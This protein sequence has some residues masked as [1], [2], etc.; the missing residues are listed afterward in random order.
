[1]KI[2]FILFDEMTALDLVGVY[3]AL[4]RLNTMG[5][6]PDVGWDLCALSS[7]V[8]AT[9]GMRFVATRSRGSLEGYDLLV[10]PGGVGT[11]RLLLQN[12]E[13]YDFIQWIQ[14][15][16][17]VPLK[18]SVCTGALILGI[19]GFLQGKP[20]TT[21]PS[22]YD[23][24]AR[25]CSQVLPQ[26]IVDA[27]DVITAGGVAASLDLGLYLVEKFSGEHGRLAV[28][29]QMDYPAYPIPALPTSSSSSAHPRTS[30]YQ[31]RTQETEVRILLNLDGTGS[32]HIDT[33]IGFLD[34]M[35]THLAVH[36]LFDLDIQ[37]KGDL[38]V[39]LHHTVED[40]AL[41]LGE[42]FRQ[43]LGDRQG[44]VRMASAYAPMDESLAFVAVD[45]SGRPYTVFEGAWHSPEVG[46][47]PTSLFQHFLES[48][49]NN[50]RCNLHTR[51]VAGRDDHHQAEALFK[52][53]ARALDAATHLDARRSGVIPSTKGTLAG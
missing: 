30:E 14:T 15:G 25:Y 31:R 23:E 28:Q 12:Q 33:G 42:S 34:H 29:K 43:A 39:D 44:I 17:G 37:A 19:A 48:F 38:F 1:M 16:Q 20:A 13:G 9:G 11:R 7:E 35:L 8:V 10:V 47:I 46:G 2:A 52:A 18:A 32:H 3:D 41:A 5:L 24:L 21:H 22:A 51:L 50:A 6:L 53:L 40:V 49:A 36:G 26:R 45:F 27:G 4:A